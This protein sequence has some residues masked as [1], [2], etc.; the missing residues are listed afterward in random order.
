MP[1]RTVNILLIEDNSAD[2]RLVA[3]TLS[4]DN[5]VHFNIKH[6]ER[7]FNAL[8]DIDESNIDIILLDL[9]LPDTQGLNTLIL[10]AQALP[11]T[12]IIVFTGLNDEELG[13]KI[14][15]L[16]A[17]D[18]IV[19]S[20][21]N[22]KLLSHSILYAIERKKV[23]ETLQISQLQYQSVFENI[24]EGILQFTPE[25][26]IITANPALVKMLGYESLEKLLQIKTIN[27]IFH[28]LEELEFIL[29][30]LHSTEKIEN[31]SVNWKKQ[32]GSLILVQI[33]SII[34]HKAKSVLYF[35]VIVENL[36]KQKNLEMQVLQSQKL[37]TIGNIAGGIAHD[38]NN[39]LA[40][41][42]MDIYLMEK[43]I[44]NDN[45]AKENIEHTKEV[46]RQ[47]TELTNQILTFSRKKVLEI[48]L[49]SL[50][51]IINDFSNTIKRLIEENIE[52]EF[53]LSNN[54]D[55][56]RCDRIQLEQVLLNLC[57]NARD[58]MPIGGKLNVKTS[59]IELTEDID[60]NTPEIKTGRFIC[61]DV[62]DTGS[63][64]S[65]EVKEKIFQPFFTTKEPGKGTGM[66]LSV[67]YSIVHLHQGFINVKS[68]EIG[69]SFQIFFPTT[70]IAEY[71]IDEIMFDNITNSKKGKSE[72]ILLI[73]DNVNIQDSIKRVLESC[74]YNIIL[75]KDGKSALDIFEKE[76]DNIHLIFS[77]LVL[78][79]IGGVEV[80]EKVIKECSHMKFLFTSGYNTS[81]GHFN[82]IQKNCLEFIQKPYNPH[83]LLEKIRKILED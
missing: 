50:N 76:K 60:K 71:D 65:P 64:I 73:E 75:A 21:E 7:F 79:K 27:H 66:G 82:F 24:S 31:Y 40:A 39:L 35:E 47:A 26:E 59:V 20:Y 77:D 63:G 10:T 48:K 72:T 29:P 28:D 17:Q 44:P 57:V 43:R 78:P 68:N 16:G 4:E 70:N 33:N 12:P 56:I 46:I 19:K 13:K 80:Y 55:M 38:F 74:D 3:E 45:P 51:K 37:E 53:E 54:L 41:L 52:I 34:K 14:L 9:S 25:K 49:Y 22:M 62:S 67:V 32:D 61:L 42:S 81:K 15:R 6:V 36:T 58:A 69:T 8:N 30:S 1:L 83:D 11:D 5:K 23:E 2:A 18:F